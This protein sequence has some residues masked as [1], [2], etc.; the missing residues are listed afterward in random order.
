MKMRMKDLSVND[1]GAF[2]H[3]YYGLA[4]HTIIEC[5]RT[6]GDTLEGVMSQAG[7]QCMRMQKKKGDSCFVILNIG[8]KVF[9]LIILYLDF[10]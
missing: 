5:K 2:S 6:D 8:M 10:C 1:P 7:D 9:I 4:D 3:A